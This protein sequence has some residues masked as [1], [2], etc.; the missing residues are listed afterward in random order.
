MCLL[1]YQGGRRW[2]V[3][4]VLAKA[5][6]SWSS[7]KCAVILS[8]SSVWRRLN[9]PC[10][11]IATPGAAGAASSA[12]SVGAEAKRPRCPSNSWNVIVVAML[13]TQPAWDLATQP[14]PHVNGITGSALPVCAV[15]AVGQLRA[16]IGMPSGLKITASAP[17]APSSMRKG[18]TAQF[19]HAAMKTMTMRAR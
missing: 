16:R 5:S 15:R 10:L 6:M 3:C 12:M 4:C 2:C 7:A 11:S 19:A 17:G 8:T 9:G 14:G 18:T 13:T 1:P